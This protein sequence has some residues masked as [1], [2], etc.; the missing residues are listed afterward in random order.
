MAGRLLRLRGLMRFSVLGRLQVISDDGAELRIPQLRQRGLLT[1]LLLHANQAMSVSRLTESLWE[2]DGPAPSPGALRTQIWALR[3][4]LAPAR[5]LRTSDYSGY[6]LEVHP[7]ELDAA[8]FRRLAG[9]GRDALGTGDLPDAASALRQALALWGDPPLA[10]VPATL[11]MGPA[12]QRL[13]DERHAARDLLNEARLSLG[14]HAAL[15][16]ELREGTA[17]E[18]ANERLWE[19]LMLALHRDGRTADALAAY[20]QARAAMNDE[21]GLEP[22]HRIQRL[23]HRILTG[24]P[25]LVQRM[26][27]WMRARD[28]DL[29]A[30][31]VM[32]SVPVPRQLPA[33][34]AHFAGRAP[35]LRALVELAELAAGRNGQAG[36]LVISAI[37]GAA[38]VGK[39]A[40]AL[41]L[42]HQVADR[43]PDGQLYVNLRGFDPSGE[44]VTQAQAI[45]G[46]LDALGVEAQAIPADVDAQA[47][48]YRSLLAG[49]RMLVLLD[50]ARDA[51][52]VRPLLPGS[53]GC[54]VAVTSRNQ[55]TG[56]AAVDGARLLNLGVLG[57][58][59]AR[60]LLAGRLGQGRLAAEPEAVT[61]LIR[62]CAGLPLALAITAARAAASPLHPLAALAAR[63]RDADSRFDT[64]DVGEPGSS[65]RSAFS[66]SYA[67]LSTTAAR[68][69][70]LLALHPG[71][72]IGTP[73]AA[74]LAG[75]PLP[76]ARAA[77]AEL[78]A[79]SLLA[80][81]SPDRYVLHDLLRAYAAEQTGLADSE[82]DR[83]AAIHR[84]LDHY[85]H[86]A[87]P[88]AV[89]LGWQHYP[90]SLA[91]PRPGVTPEKLADHWQAWFA[92]EQRA[93]VAAVSVAAG[94][95]CDGHA[96]QLPWVIWGYLELQGRWQELA[97]V[98]RVAL[99]AATRLGD[100]VR[101]AEAHR[102]LAGALGSL[103]DYDQ[104]RA[105]LEACRDLYR[106][107]GDQAG[108]GRAHYSLA[109]VYGQQSRWA[110]AL[111]HAEQA[112]ALFEAAGDRSGQA[113]AH[114]TI[115]MCLAGLRNY[116]QARVS[117]QNAIALN[118]DIGD[119]RVE[120]HAWDSLGYVE[121]QLG[122]LPDAIR[123]YQR[124]LRILRE[125]GYR[126]VEAT[127][128]ANLGDAYHAG[129]NTTMARDAW[130]D[131]LAILD[132][133]HN[134]DAVKIR[135]KLRSLPGGAA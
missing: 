19:Q 50:N 41:Q 25:E 72:D 112:L 40:L 80:E 120:A 57:D 62:L 27:G 67:Q 134:T 33:G 45:R 94:N 93:L 135:A 97:T 46:F 102:I 34:V 103:A 111:S 82:S 56:L 16:P 130:R 109:W 30:G 59:E 87:Y 77:L 122:H 105:H 129:G 8:E 88:V 17:A 110:D 13:L 7:G 12:V 51:A 47:G 133:L 39:T 74:S 54:L 128:L 42:A 55:L 127:I 131:A 60:D 117:C 9:Q 75:I 37:G 10:D 119:R 86:T 96:R 83:R 76:Q 90:I 1:V 2:E 43:F 126:F 52:Q 92:A 104:A 44:P 64:L 38:G 5:R 132:D 98:Q 66:W 31:P 125:L 123:C 78:S 53:G 68:V 28:P 6:Q 84:I 95:G 113:R 107:A 22:G 89:K 121:H 114:N 29:A 14:E 18:P 124:A 81:P 20:Q 85:L 35:E 91:P 32:P 23:H 36:T 58:A 63:L 65:V 101:Q 3:R 24:D 49:R 61:Q 70:R 73:A 11:A 106:Q 108:E 4:L 79:A 26:H 71:P 21:L 100:T 116:Q 15:I 115:G 48:L 118:Q 69:F 99:D